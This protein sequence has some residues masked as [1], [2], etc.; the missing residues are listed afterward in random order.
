MG[1]ATGEKGERSLKAS[2]FT[3]I[4]RGPDNLSS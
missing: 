3:P 4:L 2:I 1:F